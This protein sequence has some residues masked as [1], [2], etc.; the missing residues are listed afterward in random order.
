MMS[1]YSTSGYSSLML[2][3]NFPTASPIISNSL[4][5]A[6]KVYLS[7]EKASKSMPL[8]YS[9]IESHESIMS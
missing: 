6:E 4:I 5:T 7:F 8:T 3:G 9:I 2:S 1:C